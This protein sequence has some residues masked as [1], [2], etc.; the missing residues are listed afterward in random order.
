VKALVVAGVLSLGSALVFGAAAL[1]ASLFP[2][3]A[4]VAAGV[5]D[6]SQ[7][8]WAP[9]GR[10]INAGIKQRGLVM[11]GPVVVTGPNVVVD[12]APPRVARD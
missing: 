6:Q 10:L 8:V 3:G 11:G 4:T 9:D 5:M 1:T 7:V 12:P 2:N